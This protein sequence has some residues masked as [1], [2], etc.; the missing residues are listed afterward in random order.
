MYE[1]CQKCV[2]GKEHIKNC[3][4]RDNKL[5]SYLRWVELERNLGATCVSCI[6]NGITGFKAKAYQKAIASFQ[7]LDM[8]SEEK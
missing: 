6:H 2:T 5:I 3:A 4:D 8:F 7:S 1:L